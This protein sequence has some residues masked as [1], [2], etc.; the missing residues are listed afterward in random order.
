MRSVGQRRGQEPVLL[1][2]MQSARVGKKKNNNPIVSP[3]P[4]LFKSTGG[5][6]L[7]KKRSRCS[8]CILVSFCWAGTRSIAGTSH[9]FICRSRWAGRCSHPPVPCLPAPGP[10]HGGPSGAPTCSR[11][12]P[13]STSGQGTESWLSHYIYT[14]TT[15]LP[16]LTNLLFSLLTRRRQW[17]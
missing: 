16:Y 10:W 15:N 9:R 13:G 4:R 12:P 5:R 8:R 14:S 2:A 17:G 11:A 1:S 6:T 3:P 7:K